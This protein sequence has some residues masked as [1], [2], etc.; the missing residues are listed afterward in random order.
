MIW[1]DVTSMVQTKATAFVEQVGSRSRVRLNFVIAR[2]ASS[3]HGQTS[4]QDTPILDATVS[5]NA[6]ER[7]E[8][9]IFA[10]A[11]NG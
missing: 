6:F 3:V 1:F 7:I 8:N 10:R 9:A 11:D 4:R 5:Q 2:Q